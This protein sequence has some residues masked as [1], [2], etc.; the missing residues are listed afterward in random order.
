MRKLLLSLFVILC[1]FVYAQQSPDFSDM[2]SWVI[3]D[4]DTTDRYVFADTAFVRLSPDRKAAAI[5]TLFA[6]DNITVNGTTGSGLTIRGIRGPWVKVS[7]TKN[8]EQKTGYMW[9]GLISC[10]PLRRGDVK[11]IY[12][13]EGR[14]DSVYRSDSGKD[15]IRGYLVTLKIVQA[16]RIIAKTSLVTPDDESANFSAGKVMSGMG[17]T[18]VQN[19]IVLTFSGEACAIPTYDYYLAWTR[20]NQLV[21][22]PDKTNVSDAG[23]YY[24]AETFTFPNEKNGRPDMIVWSMI[25]EEATD[26]VDKDGNNILKTTEKKS[27]VYT[28]D[29]ERIAPSRP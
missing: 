3:Y 4:G 21:R 8:G 27:A 23:A 25:T 29:G 24:H 15:T 20:S 19:I 6:G 18:N 9:Q 5:D 16:G 22:F 28:W 12:G 11:F 2:R 26:E 14:A 10:A 13:I 1:N 7:Y 17:L